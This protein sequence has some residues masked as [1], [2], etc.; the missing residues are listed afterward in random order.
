LPIRS[1]DVI[2]GD[3]LPPAAIRDHVSRYAKYS[4]AFGK[5]K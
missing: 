2:D 4:I 5:F 3:S 1:I